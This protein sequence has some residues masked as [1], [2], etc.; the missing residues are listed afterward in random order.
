M[1]INPARLGSRNSPRR[2][3]LA[4]P[5]RPRSTV[6]RPTN[7]QP[8]P[9]ECLREPS[10]SLWTCPSS[11]IA[12]TRCRCLATSRSRMWF[13]GQPGNHECV[14][15]GRRV[16]LTQLLSRPSSGRSVADGVLLRAGRRPRRNRP[17]AWP[18]PGWT[19]SWCPCSGS[20]TWANWSPWRSE[21]PG[22]HRS[23]R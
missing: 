7:I 4:W 5:A 6:A 20:G 19:R 10:C 16:R 21:T 22:R 3:T 11:L 8:R 2:Q 13:L 23:T 17:S 15:N 9:I 1:L 14:S 12:R 18:A